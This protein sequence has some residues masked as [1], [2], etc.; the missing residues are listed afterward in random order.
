M[1][2]AFIILGA[3][4]ALVGASLVVTGIRRGPD[5]APRNA[6]MLIG[7]MMLTAFGIVIAGFAIVYSNT[8]PLDLNAGAM[9]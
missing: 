8:A 1:M 6:V 9:Q 5:S 4:A 7:G 3:I 2:T